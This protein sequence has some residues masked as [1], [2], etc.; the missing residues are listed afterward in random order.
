MADELVPTPQQL[1][2]HLEGLREAAGL[3]VEQLAERAALPL[4]RV[5]LIE[6]GAVDPGLEE[7]TKYARG[8]NMPLSKVFR[9]WENKN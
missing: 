3:T 6:L 4:D 2:R 5:L 7:L 8:L 1:G 9:S